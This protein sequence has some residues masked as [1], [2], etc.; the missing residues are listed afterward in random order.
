MTTTGQMGDVMKESTYA[1]AKKAKM[2]LHFPEGAIP[3][4]SPLASITIVF[5]LLSLASLWIIQYIRVLP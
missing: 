3:K 4:N 1:F 5:A 2:H